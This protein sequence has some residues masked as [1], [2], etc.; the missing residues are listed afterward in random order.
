MQ[1][2]NK[3]PI[4]YPISPIISSMHKIKQLKLVKMNLWKNNYW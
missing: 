2:F 4:S 1:I 3:E